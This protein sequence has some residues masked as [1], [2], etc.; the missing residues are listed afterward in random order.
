[1][2]SM[3]GLPPKNGNRAPIAG[4]GRGRHNLHMVL[5]YHCDRSTACRLCVLE[6]GTIIHFIHRVNA[7]QVSRNFISLSMSHGGV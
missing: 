1:M 2:R 7:V 4:G 6:P 3:A 5:P